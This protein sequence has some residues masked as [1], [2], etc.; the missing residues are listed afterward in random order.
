MIFTTLRATKPAASDESVVRIMV[1]LSLIHLIVFLT[2]GMMSFLS[3][4]PMLVSA[5]SMSGANSVSSSFVVCARSVFNP[6]TASFSLS[7]A[8]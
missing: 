8:S 4:F 5:F 6:C 2:A 3:V 1:L 7:G